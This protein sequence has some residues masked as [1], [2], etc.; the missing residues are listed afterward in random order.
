MSRSTMIPRFLSQGNR[1]FIITENLHGLLYGRYNSKVTNEV[2]QP[3]RLLYASS[4]QLY[5][6][7]HVESATVSCLELFQ[8]TA[9]PLRV[10]T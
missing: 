2:L 6:D 3:Y 7:S 1:S 4:L 5:S 8:V 10:K 9:P